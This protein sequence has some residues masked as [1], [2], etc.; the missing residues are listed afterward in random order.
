[1]FQI[2]L[3]EMSPASCDPSE[4]MEPK[5]RIC[6]IIW[7]LGHFGLMWPTG[8]GLSGPP[9]QRQTST[10]STID[11]WDV[12]IQP[13][14]QACKPSTLPCPE[15]YEKSRGI[16]YKAF[17]ENKSFK[18]SAATCH[19]DGGT[20]AM[21]RDADTTAFLV[22]LFSLYTPVT[23]ETFATAFWFGL[24]DQHR[25]GIFEWMDG[26]GLGAYRPWCPGQP[27]NMKI[28]GSDEDC[29][30]TYHTSHCK[31]NDLRCDLKLPFVCQVT[32]GTTNEH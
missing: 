16:C 18:D 23:H 22:S 13:C 5:V 1:M 14:G 20:L 2:Y 10:L 15:G 27:N 28:H 4:E 12:T 25:E 19:E 3:S 21:P 17:K 31:W 29:V 30:S 24:H 6:K 7:S 26:S 11:G 9:G 8:P 32:P